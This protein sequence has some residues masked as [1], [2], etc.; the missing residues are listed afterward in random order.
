[1]RADAKRRRPDSAAP[2]RFFPSAD[3]FFFDAL[4][5]DR[6]DRVRRRFSV[7]GA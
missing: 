6:P 5:S 3:P 4:L 7:S 2:L 1:M